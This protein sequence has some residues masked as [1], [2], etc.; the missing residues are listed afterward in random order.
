MT[1]TRPKVKI[2]GRI[3][4]RGGRCTGCKKWIYAQ[5]RKQWERAVRLPR[6]HC[7]K[8]GW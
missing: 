8:R 4:Q 6:P 3:A 5:T 1:T 7:G 2:F